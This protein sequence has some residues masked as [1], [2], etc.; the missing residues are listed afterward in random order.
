ME[1]EVEVQG[2]KVEPVSVGRAAHNLSH[3]AAGMLVKVLSKTTGRKSLGIPES[4]TGIGKTKC[5]MPG[6]EAPDPF[7]PVTDKAL[8]YGKKP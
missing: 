6:E 5:V 4:S 3:E 7:L 1:F 8:G 2:G